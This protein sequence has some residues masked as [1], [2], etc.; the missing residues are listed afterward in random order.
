MRGKVG[1]TEEKLTYTVKPTKE[2]KKWRKIKGKEIYMNVCIFPLPV[3]HLKC[4][5]LLK[6]EIIMSFLC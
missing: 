5:T 1:T 4:E 6:T 3:S 2:C